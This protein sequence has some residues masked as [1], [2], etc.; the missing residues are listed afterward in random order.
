MEWIRKNIN[1][2]AHED[3]SEKTGSKRT[4]GEDDDDGEPYLHVRIG[5]SSHPKDSIL[6]SDPTALVS[7][8]HTQLIMSHSGWAI[9]HFK[10]RL[11]LLQVILDGVRGRSSFRGLK[12]SFDA[13]CTSQITVLSTR[14]VVYT[15]MSALGT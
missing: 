11:E 8:V 13:H 6:S 5:N 7:R 10:S 2:T 12:L 3:N 1:C 14:M 15:A 4:R 9:R